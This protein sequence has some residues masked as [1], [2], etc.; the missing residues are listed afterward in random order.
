MH[1]LVHSFSQGVPHVVPP[2]VFPVAVWNLN[3][4]LSA[5]LKPPFESIWVIP[6]LTLLQ[7][8]AFHVAI[9]SALWVSVSAAM[10]GMAALSCMLPHLVLHRDMVGF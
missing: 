5:L 3:L 7:K 4:V 6:L 2:Y 1:F 10:S 9:P 8:V